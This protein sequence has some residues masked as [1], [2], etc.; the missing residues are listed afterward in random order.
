METLL[1]FSPVDPAISPLW[2]AVVFIAIWCA[3]ERIHGKASDGVRLAVLTL[4]VAWL[5]FT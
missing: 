1:A 4:F 5:A 3:R 2:V